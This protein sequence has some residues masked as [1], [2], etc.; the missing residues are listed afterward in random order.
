M[1]RYLKIS[2]IKEVTTHAINKNSRDLKID[3]KS[4]SK[5]SSTVVSSSS[6]VY[7]C[8]KNATTNA[9]PIASGIEI[10]GRLKVVTKNQDHIILKIQPFI[11]TTMNIPAI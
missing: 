2:Y 4:C 7:W 6:S 8:V 9:I 1:Y 5:N 10:T 3:L 11:V